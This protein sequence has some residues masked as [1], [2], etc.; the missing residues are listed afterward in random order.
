MWRVL[1]LLL[2]FGCKSEA[3]EKTEPDKVESPKSVETPA[4][5]SKLVAVTKRPAMNP[6]EDHGPP[7]FVKRGSGVFDDSG[8]RYFYGTGHAKGI[9][10]MMRAHMLADRAA[11]AELLNQMRAYNQKIL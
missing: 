1:V 7:E 6:H 4:P 11:N 2:C 9:D 5:P 3:P 8:K 10:N